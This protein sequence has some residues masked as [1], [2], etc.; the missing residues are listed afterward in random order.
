[1]ELPFGVPAPDVE[2]DRPV[3]T[4]KVLT[5]EVE[6]VGRSKESLND[7]RAQVR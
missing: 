3:A 5:G 4:G 1:M 2:T 6:G 7:F